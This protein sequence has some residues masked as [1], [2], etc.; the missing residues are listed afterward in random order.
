M[1][2]PQALTEIM[3]VVSRANKYIDETAPWVLGKDPEKAPRLAS[4]LYNLCEVIRIVSVLISPFMP[5]TSPLIQAQ[6]GASGDLTVW[7][8]AKT[9]GLLPAGV[10]V[11]K[12]EVLFP[13]IDAAKEMKELEEISAAKKAAAEKPAAQ[14][15][16]PEEP[17]APVQIGIEDFAKVNLIA[18]KIMECTPVEKSD[19]LL[20]LL[21]DDG[22]GNIRQIVSG[23]A[24]WY[25]PAD[26][27]G[28][29]VP[30]VANLKPVKLRGV[31]SNGMILAADCAEDDVKVLFLDNSIPAGSKIR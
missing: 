13:R 25:S 22:S 8:S 1:Q 19:K 17:A 15:T 4:V 12:G 3:K 31:E 9:F 2:F 10:T 30:I 20:R 21:V 28:K 7:E 5:H 29:T 14:P 18:A 6:I 23:I 11:Q 27:I 24:K 16:V 26:L